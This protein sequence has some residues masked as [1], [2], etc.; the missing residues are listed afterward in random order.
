M[1]SELDGPLD[2]CL[3]HHTFHQH[4]ASGIPW[5]MLCKTY[6]KNKTD[7]VELDKSCTHFTEK[8]Q[9]PQ[10]RKCPTAVVQSENA[11]ALIYKKYS[12]MSRAILEQ[13]LAAAGVVVSEKNI[14]LSTRGI[15]TAKLP[16]P[17][18][19]VTAKYWIFPR[20]AD[21]SLPVLKL[22]S[23]TGCGKALSHLSPDENA[24]A[25]H[26]NDAYKQ[27][28]ET[29]KVALEFNEGALINYDTFKAVISG[30]DTTPSGGKL[31]QARPA[32]KGSPA[33]A[34]SG[35]KRWP[36]ASLSPPP[37]TNAASYNASTTQA[38]ASLT[39]E[40]LV[41]SDMGSGKLP[42]TVII[43]DEEDDPSDN[44]TAA[45]L[46]VL[47]HNRIRC[48]LWQ[49]AVFGSD[50]NDR[51]QCERAGVTQRGRKNV[52]VANKLDEWAETYR[53]VG[54]L[55]AQ[56]VMDSTP[57]E[58][59]AALDIL[60]AEYGE[61]PT[62]VFHRLVAKTAAEQ[63]DQAS[64]GDYSK[65]L[66]CAFPWVLNSD[67][68]PFNTADPKSAATLNSIQDKM[69]IYKSIVLTDTLKGMLLDKGGSIEYA[70]KLC[71]N[72][73]SKC[74]AIMNQRDF[75]PP[76][77]EMDAISD[78]AASARL[79]MCVRKPSL[80]SDSIF[81][82]ALSEG[83]EFSSAQ[84]PGRTC[85]S[86]V[87]YWITLSPEL[88]TN[89]S[90]A[91]SRMDAYTETAK[92]LEISNEEISDH[93]ISIDSAFTIDDV[94]DLSKAVC[95]GLKAI[96][97][98]HGAQVGC[99]AEALSA[100][101]P[102][103]ISNLFDACAAL[104]K[105]GS[106]PPQQVMPHISSVINEAT[107]VIPLS[108]KISELEIQLGAMVRN[109]DMHSR[110]HEWL[111]ANQAVTANC[112]EHE[113][114]LLDAAITKFQG[115]NFYDDE[116]LC[117][118]ALA[119]LN[120]FLKRCVED[121]P[122][123]FPRDDVVGFMNSLQQFISKDPANDASCLGRGKLATFLVECLECSTHLEAASKVKAPESL[124]DPAHFLMQT[125]C[126]QAQH[127]MDMV[128]ARMDGTECMAVDP[129]LHTLIQKKLMCSVRSM[130]DKGK[131]HL[132]NRR[133]MLEI[134]A[135][136]SL[137]AATAVLTP[138]MGGLGDNKS[139]KDTIPSGK[140]WSKYKAHIE[141]TLGASE[142][143]ANLDD[144]IKATD[145]VRLSH[146]SIEGC[147]TG[148]WKPSGRGHGDL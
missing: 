47:R 83:K 119:A 115:A 77:E 81:L 85:V 29:H 136:E 71:E 24:Y 106:H 109:N 4:C 42:K 74:L 19:A 80:L 105:K 79:V 141:A 26:G 60:R 100:I 118:A 51:Y 132:Q 147:K 122:Q 124:S 46:R 32:R 69:A 75:K 125:A 88:K 33:S 134:T 142:I 5:R 143:A 108:A 121:F 45:G 120:T 63:R 117:G 89:F 48:D 2:K 62:E 112:S 138:L 72:I 99:V 73:N 6:H 140:T 113:L 57:A 103:I 40:S 31:E 104:L 15:P 35:R 84:A 135:T 70:C 59:E 133:A 101:M 17:G 53:K 8:G 91:V 144:H 64:H 3:E 137:D 36:A 86:S 1:S 98:S 55:S 14:E 21:K 37:T 23:E 78:V 52:D 50:G 111:S 145:K 27:L 22:V 38:D 82:D 18:T 30:Q 68:S 65:M 9:L 11:G 96:S 87:A 20:T 94:A 76:A 139:Y 28:T 102:D 90:S 58:R 123:P 54:R 49:T 34:P 25:S 127:G 110:R 116:E 146:K 66:T 43:A 97:Y 16:S 148:D 41:E 12:V 61:I 114:G 128:N 10:D 129:Q 56:F 131:D 95:R 39:A 7:Q 107:V 13:E 67:D 126:L 130:L 92:R 44:E 93:A